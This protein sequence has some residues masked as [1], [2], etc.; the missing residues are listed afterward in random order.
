MNQSAVWPHLF[1]RL[2]V[3]PS[4]WGKHRGI[5]CVPAS[6]SSKLGSWCH[7]HDTKGDVRYVVFLF[8]FCCW[9]LCQLFPPSLSVTQDMWKQ[10]H[11]QIMRFSGWETQ[12]RSDLRNTVSNRKILF[13]FSSN[14]LFFLAFSLPSLSI[15]RKW[16]ILQTDLKQAKLSSSRVVSNEKK[17]H[18]L[19]DMRDRREYGAWVEEGLEERGFSLL[20]K[21][22]VPLR[23]VTRRKQMN[24]KF[25]ASSRLATRETYTHISNPWNII[26][27]QRIDEGSTAGR[28]VSRFLLMTIFLSTQKHAKMCD[29]QHSS[30]SSKTQ[31][32]PSLPVKNTF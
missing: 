8:L 12:E 15:R 25:D 22:Q 20:C 10:T 21:F 32:Y 29:K 13:S 18:P 1:P 19:V 5:N 27:F 6:L 11:A 3:T 14:D 4:S 28:R 9:I 23:R 24:S 31:N 26:Y 16:C 17:N 30:S 2:R 7:H